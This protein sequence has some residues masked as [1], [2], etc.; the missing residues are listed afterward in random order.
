MATNDKDYIVGSTVH[1][2]VGTRHPE[3]R[4]PLDPPSP[5]VLDMLNL[6]GVDDLALPENV[7]FTKITP[8]EYRLSLQT[9]GLVPGVY[10][11]RAKATDAAGDIALSED[12]F[13]LRPAT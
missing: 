4:S 8:G 3:N 2:K 11:W 7:T 1:L 5:P 9:T 12:T 6:F 13:I 10:T